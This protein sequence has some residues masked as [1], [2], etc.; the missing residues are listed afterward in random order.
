MMARTDAIS[1]ML[2]Q[3]LN[4]T[5]MKY[6]ELL[7]AQAQLGRPFYNEYVPRCNLIQTFSKLHSQDHALVW[8]SRKNA[9]RQDLT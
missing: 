1:I 5:P 3:A 2:T 6:A 8:S 9:T 7:W 4:V